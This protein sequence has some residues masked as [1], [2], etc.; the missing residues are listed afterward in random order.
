MTRKICVIT[1]SRAEYGLLRLLM[2]GIRD[3]AAL[4]LQLLVTGT[5]LSPQFGMTY[6]EIEQ[7]GFQIDSKV[8]IPLADNSA[9]GVAKAVGHGVIALTDALEALRPDMVV[10]LGDRFEILAAASAA[11]ILGIPIAHIHG[12]ETTEGAFDEAIRHSVTKMSSLHFVAAEDYR[13]RVIQLGENP[14][15]T[16]LVGGLGVDL[17]KQTKL[18]DRAA[19]EAELGFSL[20]QQSLLVT[21]HPATRDYADP[22]AQM[23]ELLAA[24]AA[25]NDTRLVFTM[26]N[27][28]TGSLGIA[29]QVREFV[30]AHANARAYDSLG[31][32]RYLSCMAQVDAVVGNSSSGLLEA[33][34]L[35]IPTVNIGDRQR[36]RLKASSVIDC[37]P[38]RGEIATALRRLYS[39]QFRQTLAHG[40]ESPYGDGGA[41]ARIVKILRAQP[42]ENLLRKSFYDLPA[43]TFPE[44]A[45]R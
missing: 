4:Q 21:F 38:E 28:D 39:P 44:A 25:L 27:A 12:G 11:L 37:A 41:A 30:A 35:G 17:I 13:R 1:G 19:V 22:A 2:Q 20:G 15:R 33:P 26:P 36:G 40:I 32:H 7:D 6:R 34:S 10:L 8:E 3:D 18:L 16:F 43:S 24:L 31:A 14:E 42:L 45:P 9:T 5:H 23:T 29:R